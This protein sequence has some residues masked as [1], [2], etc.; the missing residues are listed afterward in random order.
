MTFKVTPAQFPLLSKELADSG[1]VTMTAAPTSSAGIES[2]S[3]THG[4]IVGQYTYDPNT[5]TLT[6]NIV[7]GGGLIVNHEVKDKIQ[8]AINALKA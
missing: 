8:N 6:A 2:G 3:I 4:A 1:Q 5:L 7:E